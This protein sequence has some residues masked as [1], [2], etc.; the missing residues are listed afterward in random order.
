MGPT[1]AIQPV[2]KKLLSILMLLTVYVDAANQFTILGPAGSGTFGSTVTMLPSGNFVVT[3]PSYD[4]PSP[5]TSDVG[6]AYLYKPDGTLISKLRG[7]SASDRVGNGGITVL[8]S[9]N[10]VVLSIN[11]NGTL[12][13]ATWGDGETGFPAGA[14]TIVGPANSFIGSSA[15]DFSLGLVY[16]L[17]T[18]HYIL[19]LPRWDN[20]SLT[21]TDAGAVAWG[22]G[23]TGSTGIIASSN[24]LVGSQ[25]SDQVGFGAGAPKFLPNGHYVVVSGLWSDGAVSGV[26]ATTWCNGFTGTS[27]NVSSS[28]SLIG[29]TTNDGTNLSVTVLPNGSYTVSRPKW[30]LPSPATTDVGA[31]T[32]CQADGPTTGVVSSA[33]SA[34]GST[35]GDE[36]GVVYALAD[37]RY[38]IACATWDDPVSSIPDAGII[39]IGDASAGLTGALDRN[40][41]LVGAT[42]GDLN[43]ATFVQLTNGN[44]VLSLPGWD[45]PTSSLMN[46]GLVI[47]LKSRANLIGST[48]VTMGLTGSTSFDSV[49]TVTPLANGNYLVRTS[50][51]NNPVGNISDV[52]AVTWCSGRTGRTGTIS[53]ANSLV[54]TTASDLIGSNVITLPGS[55]GHYV[56]SA[57]NWDDPGSSVVN[58]GAVTWGDGSRGVKGVISSANS[59]IGS[60]IDDGVSLT[61]IALTNGHYVA[62]FRK[63]DDLEEGVVNAGAMLWCDG[64]RGRKGHVRKQDALVGSTADDMDASSLLALRNG[65]FFLASTFWDHTALSQANVGALTWG[66]G[67]RGLVGT[68]SPSNS[69]VGATA[70]DQL[71]PPSV[72]SFLVDFEGSVLCYSRFADNPSGPI[73]NAGALSVI[74]E[75]CGVNGVIGQDN[76]ILGLIGSAPTIPTVDYDP[77][78]NRVA[79]GF[80]LA[81]TVIVHEPSAIQSLGRSGTSAPGAVDIAFGKPGFTAVNS[82]GEVLADWTLTGSGSTAGRSRGL[83]DS[84]ELVLQTGTTLGVLGSGLPGNAKASALF[85]QIHQQPWKGLFQATVSGTG[86]TAINNRLLLMDN[87]AG[88]SMLKRTG[89]AWGVTPQTNAQFSAFTEVL[90]SHDQDLI[91]LTYKLKTNAAIPVDSGNDTG[92]L[93]MN[94]T[95]SITNSLPREG[96]SSFGGGGT[97][98]QFSGRATAAQG[99][100]IHFIGSHDPAGNS[101]PVPAVFRMKKDGTSLSRPAQVGGNVTAIPGATFKSIV[102]ISQLASQAV[103]L[104]NLNGTTAS[105]NQV[106]YALPGNLVLA[107]KGDQV[108]P[109]NQPDLVISKILRYWTAGPDQL[110]LQAQLSGGT[111]KANNQA[112]ILRQND[113][114]YLILA[115]TGN[116]LPG[117]TLK[118]ISAVEVHP[119]SGKYALLGTLSGA[120]ASA[121]QALWIGDSQAGNPT[122]LSTLRSPALKLRKGQI[123]RSGSGQSNLVRSIAMKPAADASGAGGRG[124]AQIMSANGD[125]AITITVDRNLQELV[126]VE[127]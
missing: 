19:F 11:W 109:V 70:E 12:G 1:R 108:D 16:P 72:F 98:G 26:G 91:A 55:S 62:L 40:Q 50:Q 127:R 86:I 30:N 79:M 93:L 74:N 43:S 88:V 107:R 24:A 97:F 71:G 113:S 46:V 105:T 49:G 116:A 103:V 112:L 51:W 37:G 32:W 117:G 25:T 38:A 83:F 45:N 13:A 63:W 122:T 14:E 101:P 120:P 69:L 7:S 95:G 111:T 125:V 53:P 58:A 99:E 84:S 29:G 23:F 54:G 9:G 28:N 4:L 65:N 90:Q 47:F 77:V 10:F 104:A 123:Y 102:G 18:G 64:R 124:L 6:A 81:N 15:N 5:A 3:D 48:N 68:I 76:S 42:T 73:V 57:A 87:G 22:N 85:G 119:V 89:Q 96:D 100:F 8:E 78:R 31:V 17:S 115:R 94:H 20:T 114:S 66:D 92:L 59:L 56:V 21:A 44:Q 34:H 33:N 27:G 36:V 110:I 106:I 41:S 67:T 2:M 52:G 61:V 126:M 121:N 35:A 118:S 80:G 60:T 39:T 82:V 75:D